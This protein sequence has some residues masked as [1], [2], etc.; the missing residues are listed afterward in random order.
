MDLSAS[1]AEWIYA[2]Q[3]GSSLDSDSLSET[4]LTTIL[5]HPS[6]GS[7]R[8]HK[9]AATLIHLCLA[10]LDLVLVP[11]QAQAQILLLLLE[12]S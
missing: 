12:V 4:M 7:F 1:S 9:A 8:R 6:P 11:A 2:V 10:D 5:P 3:S